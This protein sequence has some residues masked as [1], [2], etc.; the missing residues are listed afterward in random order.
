MEHDVP[1]ACPLDCPDGCGGIVAVR[2]GEAVRLRGTPDHPFTAGALCNKVARYLDHTRAPDRLL[3]PLRRTG[4]KGEGRFQRISWDDALAEIAQRLL[5]VRERH[6]GEAIWPFQG[7]GTLGYLQG[8]EGRYG[9]RL[10]NL[11]GASLHDASICSIAGSEGLRYTTGS[12]RGMDPEA[13]QHARLIL[14]W[15]SN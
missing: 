9:A 13:F 2:A 15:G 10:C 11:L 5:E 8:L 7:T 14:L 6:G 12:N 1:G 3:H 4:A